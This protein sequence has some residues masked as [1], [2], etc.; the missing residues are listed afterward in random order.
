MY[1][2]LTVVSFFPQAWNMPVSV[3]EENKWALYG[4][5][6]NLLLFLK[7]ELLALFFYLT[8]CT[9]SAQPLSS[10]FLPVILILVFGTVG[11][12][13]LQMVR[14]GRRGG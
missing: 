14:V 2:I 7:A 1:A 5:T 9:A 11:Y 3:T 4:M 12:F 8:W 6:K 10:K 13:I